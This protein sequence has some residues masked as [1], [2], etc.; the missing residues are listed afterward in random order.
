MSISQARRMDPHNMYI[1]NLIESNSN[2]HTKSGLQ[3]E[4]EEKIE[5]SKNIT[6]TV[7]A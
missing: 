4:S 7:S 6:W 5:Q 2:F 1:I 3:N